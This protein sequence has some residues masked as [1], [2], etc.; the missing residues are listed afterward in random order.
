MINT[1]ECKCVDVEMG[2][3]DNQTMLDRPVHMQVNVKTPICV[4]TCMV[5]EVK[6]LWD[7]GIYTN[8]CCCGHG[9]A[10][11][12]VG[13]MPEHIQQMRSMGY[14]TITNSTDPT[15]QESFYARGYN[16]DND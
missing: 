16:Y 10:P 7:I 5:D 12:F 15:R 13:V 9:S 14:Q 4:D 8:G 1:F 11:P 3:Y 2:S 6:E